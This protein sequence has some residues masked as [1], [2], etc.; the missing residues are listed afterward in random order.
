GSSARPQHGAPAGRLSAPGARQLAAG[1]QDRVRRPGRSNGVRIWGLQRSRPAVDAGEG[2]Q[3]QQQPSVNINAP[4]VGRVQQGRAGQRDRLH[5]WRGPREVH[6]HSQAEVGP[7]E[8]LLLDRQLRQ[9]LFLLHNAVAPSA[10]HPHVPP[11]PPLDEGAEV[12]HVPHLGG[13]DV[14]S[15][16]GLARVG[17]RAAASRRGEGRPVKSLG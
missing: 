12:L 4:W 15:I 16:L 5:R 3:Q 6:L 11:E 17:H 7:G 1:S 14:H 10:R 2:Q 13:P 9:G 8:Q